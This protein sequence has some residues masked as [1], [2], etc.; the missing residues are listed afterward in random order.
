MRALL[1]FLF[2]SG[3]SLSHER[4]MVD[5][6]SASDAG[7]MPAPDAGMPEEDAAV[8]EP[9]ASADECA[10]DEDCAF[11]NVGCRRYRCTSTSLAGPYYCFP[12]EWDSDGDGH[13]VAAD[14]FPAICGNDDCNDIESDVHPGAVETCDG[15]D[16]NCNGVVDEGCAEPLL[17]I[18]LDPETP[19]RDHLVM[20]STGNEVIRIRLRAGGEDIDVTSVTSLVE[21]LRNV[22]GIRNIQYWN[23]VD[24]TR[25]GTLITLGAD[26]VSRFSTTDILRIPAGTEAALAV[27][28][29]ATRYVDGAISGDAFRFTLAKA[30]ADGSLAIVA[31]TGDG[32]A[33]TADEIIVGA[34]DADETLIG[35]WMF[36]YRTVVSA[37]RHPASPSGI[38]S[39]AADQ[40][41]ARFT[42]TNSDNVDRYT[43]TVNYLVL[44][45][46]SPIVATR[47]RR[48]HVWIDAPV[49]GT[50]IAELA[51]NAG[52]TIH[53]NPGFPIFTSLFDVAPGS[54]R[55][56][57]VTIDT[58]DA[59]T[60]DTLRVD[61]VGMRFSDGV[62]SGIP[63][64]S[65]PI[66]GTTL[67][68]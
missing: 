54:S 44:A 26:R 7:H 58:Q 32:R 9:D 59:G 55:E 15:R 23:V 39:G 51:W 33:L 21:E 29:D 43:G 13:S 3:C 41:V 61:L 27:A 19:I 1:A 35:N 67:T 2:L 5:A 25:R 57:F 52:E 37:A 47:S 17:R 4:A 14:G 63:S 60:D 48:I 6:A 45:V 20:G 36:L 10:I 22:G 49:T 34:G 64:L 65:V 53:T 24:P 8:I 50:S 30:L 11:M 62:S 42:A 12:G 16:D 68:Y 40:L 18:E 31:A 46:T 28:V 66:E 38:S 56:V